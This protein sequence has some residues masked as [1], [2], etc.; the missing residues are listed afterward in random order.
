MLNILQLLIKAPIQQFV[1][2]K[3]FGESI[4]LTFKILSFLFIINL[5]GA[6]IMLKFVF[7]LF[8]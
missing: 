2:N 7:I 6:P 1:L 5:I 4:V 3:V 8:F